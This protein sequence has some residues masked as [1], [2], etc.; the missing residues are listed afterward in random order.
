MYSGRAI[1]EDAVTAPK[2]FLLMRENRSH[3][4]LFGQ[5][6]DRIEAFCRRQ[7]SDADPKQLT[8]WVQR[9]YVSEEPQYCILIAVRDEIVVGHLLASL[10]TW[11]GKKY[12]TVVQMDINKH[13]RTPM[14]EILKGFDLLTQW[15]ELNMAVGLQALV[16]DK[17]HARRLSIFYGMKPFKI[18]LRKEF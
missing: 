5:V 11:M 3:Y 7:D 1:L 17:T 9:D 12:L 6:L 8:D 4:R 15:G 16:D 13:S 14:A 10:D 18:L 2:V